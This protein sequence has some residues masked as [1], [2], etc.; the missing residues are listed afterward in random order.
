MRKLRHLLLL[1]CLSISLVGC[2]E[3][4][5]KTDV[6]MLDVITRELNL[7]VT[8]QKTGTIDLDEVVLVS[9]MTGN[10][11]QE[12]TYGY[13]EFEKQKNNYKF[14][15]IYPMMERG[16]DLRSAIYNDSYLFVVNNDNCK[17]LRIS[18]V[19]GKTNSI[20]VDQI[21]FIY[22]L[23]NALDSN[24]EYQFLNKDGKEIYP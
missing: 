6:D 2:G 11:Y 13:A 23:E 4:P 15:R 5:V 21:P 7:N 14:I 20:T 8:V 22:Y 9:Y 17:S 10:E 16:Q 3:R 24:F 19:N 18:R 12:H 1:L